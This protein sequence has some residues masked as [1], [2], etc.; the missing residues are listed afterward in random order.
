M[1]SQMDDI[2][3]D[4]IVLHGLS[5]SAKYEKYW[6]HQIKRMHTFWDNIIDEIDRNSFRESILKEATELGICDANQYNLESAFSKAKTEWSTELM[7]GSANKIAAYALNIDLQPI[8]KWTG[9][10]LAI[11]LNHVKH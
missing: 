9:S 1:E 7:I 3:K 11:N 6:K 2:V 8:V 10:Q 4:H 5:K